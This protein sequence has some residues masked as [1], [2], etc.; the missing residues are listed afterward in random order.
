MA[1]G[2]LRDQIARIESD[3][4]RVEPHPTVA[5]MDLTAPF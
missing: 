4:E 5:D 1:D 2:D 3:I